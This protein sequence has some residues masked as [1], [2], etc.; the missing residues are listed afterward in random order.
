MPNLCV[1]IGGTVGRFI[2]D[3]RHFRF[4][5]LYERTSADCFM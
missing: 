1:S 3:K 5:A 2:A 4:G